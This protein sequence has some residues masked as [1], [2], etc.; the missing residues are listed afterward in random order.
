MSVS[1][2]ISFPA[3]F[4]DV[5]VPF[6]D[7]L[8]CPALLADDDNRVTFVNEP[9]KRYIQSAQLS[10]SLPLD[11][12]FPECFTAPPDETQGLQFRD[13]DINR[14]HH[15]KTVKERIWF[16]K[17]HGCAYVIVARQHNEPE[18]DLGQV[19]TARLASLGFMVAGVCHEIANPLTA[20]H[21]TMQF[22]QSRQD[23]SAETLTRALNN[24]NDNVKRV[25]SIA[26]KLNDYTRAGSDEKTLIRL[27]LAIGESL[28]L[29]QQEY[30]SGEVAVQFQPAPESFVL[31][32]MERLQQLFTNII[33]N[34]IQ[35]MNGRGELRITIVPAGHEVEIT[36]SDSGPGIAAEHLA[37][38][39]K[40]FFT[41]KARGYGTGL[42][43]AICNEIAIEHEGTIRAENNPGAGASFRIR[44]PLHTAQQ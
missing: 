11:Q 26:N 13:L 6:I 2:Q 24:V 25:L 3:S 9:M 12:L 35:A 42:G 10:D 7:S 34:A 1:R 44:L 32:N 29:V 43:L 41:T 4:E 39:F 30:P 19:Q 21:S 37:L 20:I 5:L 15:G 27:D 38:L 33:A 18:F 22:L 40:P 16:R 31:G 23:L 14:I 8:P 28:K 17:L 36:I